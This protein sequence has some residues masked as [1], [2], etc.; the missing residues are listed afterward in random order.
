MKKRIT[1][2]LLAVIC[3]YLQGCSAKYSILVDARTSHEY[4]S[5]KDINDK[6]KIIFD[7]GESNVNFDYELVYNEIVNVFQ[8]NGYQTVDDISDAKYSVFIDFK[9]DGPH[10]ETISHSVPITGQVGVNTHTGYRYS[11]YGMTSYTYTTPRYGTVGYRNYDTVELFYTHLLSVVAYEFSMVDA[12]VTKKAW[13]LICVTSNESND[14]RKNLP[15]LLLV[16]EKHMATDTHG[17]TRV[18]IYEKQGQLVSKEDFFK[19]K[20]KIVE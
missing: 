17:K 18:E 14:F 2:I 9:V 20:E 11:P 10:T 15:A 16:L 13:Q 7:I 1:V 3:L 19:H 5:K 4:E 8:K 12:K 6:Y